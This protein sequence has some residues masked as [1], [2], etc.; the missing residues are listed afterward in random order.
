MVSVSLYDI[1]LFG[2]AAARAAIESVAVVGAGLFNLVNLNEVVA[3]LGN[4]NRL[5]CF[6]AANG[7][8]GS[9]CALFGAG[10]GGNI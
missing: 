5:L 9:G 2:N 6:L 8:V 7:A 3:E 10:R 1:S 4:Y